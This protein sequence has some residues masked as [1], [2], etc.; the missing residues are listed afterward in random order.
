[1]GGLL[2]NEEA[3]KVL[4]NLKGSMDNRIH[5][6]YNLGYKQGYEDGKQKAIEVFIKWAEGGIDE[7]NTER[8]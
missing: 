1:M 3:V 2:N 7:F 5:Q 8:D 6:I 4:K